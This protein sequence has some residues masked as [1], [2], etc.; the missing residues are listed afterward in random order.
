M[1]SAIREAGLPTFNLDLIYGAAAKRSTTGATPS[2]RRWRARSAAHLRLRPHRRGGHTAGVTARPPPRRRRPGRQVRT[3]RRAAR[4]RRPRELR[5]LELGASRATSHVTTSSTGARRTTAASAVR[6]IPTPPAGGGGTC[7]R[8][9]AT[10]KRWAAV[11]SVE[12]ASEVLD[13]DTRRFEALQL[14]VRTRDGVPRDRSR[15]RR[16]S[17]RRSGHRTSERSRP[18]RA[19]P[20]GRLMANEISLR[21][22][23]TTDRGLDVDSTLK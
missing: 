23:S 22:A 13:A 15:P 1:R 18:S 9:T 20:H 16:W 4:P 5:G 19:H 2:S 21:F 11:Q 7:E 6:R 17:S 10:S 8:R 14:A 3:R 12:A